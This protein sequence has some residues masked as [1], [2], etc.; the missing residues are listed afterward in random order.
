M[1][2][3]FVTMFKMFFELLKYPLYVNFTYPFYF[4]RS[5]LILV[6]RGTS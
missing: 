1:L 3:M 4:C 5:V 6:R 2:D